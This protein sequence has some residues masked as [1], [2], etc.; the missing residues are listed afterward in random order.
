F[1]DPGN[2]EARSLQADAL[3]QLG[4]Q[5]ESAVWRNEYLMGALELRQG[6]RDLGA[7]KLATPDL[8]GAMTLDMLLD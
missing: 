5:A 3:E 2:D 4:Y 8:L 7:V 6:V 1:A